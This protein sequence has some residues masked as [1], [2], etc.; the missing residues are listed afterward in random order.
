MNLALLNPLDNP[1]L[2]PVLIRVFLVFLFGLLLIFGLNGF[3]VADLFKKNIGQRYLGWLLIVP[4]YIAAL[5]LGGFIAEVILFLILLLGIL[6]VA[7]MSNMPKMYTVTL[8]ILSVISLYVVAYQTQYFYS[9]PLIYFMTLTTIAIKENDAKKSFQHVT[10]ALYIA[11]WLIFSLCHF[12][13]LNDLNIRLDNT[14]S[15]LLLIGFAVPLSDVFAYVIGKTFQKIHFF[16]QYKI[17]SNLSPNKTYSGSLGNIFGAILGIL[18]MNFILKD[19]LPLYHWLIIGVLIGSFG[20]IGDITKSML[21]RFYDVKDSGT[22][23]PGHGGVL[24]RIDST[25]RV[26]VVLYYYLSIVLF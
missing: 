8:A 26:V 17:A 16:D 14:K 23:I 6:E 1:L 11:I 19:Y 10:L 25:L 2:I 4:I 18:I 3:R 5:F 9:L 20:V 13:L 21:K 22:I 12:V 7:K 24:D 15:L